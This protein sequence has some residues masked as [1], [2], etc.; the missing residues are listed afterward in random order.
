M[1]KTLLSKDALIDKLVDV[2]YDYGYDGAT[3]SVTATLTDAAGNTSAQ[4]SDSAVMGDTTA[5]GAPTVLKP[6]ARR[7]RRRTV[8]RPKPSWP[9]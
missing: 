4:G 8:S 5:P 2:V 3:L 7:F 9:I 6:F 1:A